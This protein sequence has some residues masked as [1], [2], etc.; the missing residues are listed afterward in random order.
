MHEAHFQPAD[1]G[2][3]AASARVDYRGQDVESNIKWS[4]ELLMINVV[5]RRTTRSDDFD[6]LFHYCRPIVA[7]AQQP[8]EISTVDISPFFAQD[9]SEAERLTSA[10]LFVEALYHFGFSKVI[11]HGLCTD[12][13]SE[14]LGWVQKLFTLPYDEKMKAPHPPGPMPHRG[15]SGIGQEK[16]YSQ[17][18]IDTHATSKQVDVN[19]QL[20]KVSDYKASLLFSIA[21]TDLE[22][23]LKDI[24]GKLRDWE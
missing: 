17:E 16:V 7:M 15:Y 13:V 8:R 4:F 19:Q 5:V 23:H 14:A 22:Q 12:E 18:D 21:L 9:G 10:K 11:G 1:Q 20:R 24:L 2:A 6:L 3:Q